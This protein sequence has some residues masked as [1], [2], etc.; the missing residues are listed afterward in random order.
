MDKLIKKTE[1]INEML[2]NVIA[3]VKYIQENV[4]EMKK[5]E[6]YDEKLDCIYLME[7]KA[8]MLERKVEDI[9]YTIKYLYDILDEVN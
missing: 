3:E 8:E 4:D 9:T 5:V 6:T 2:K 1:N 7:H